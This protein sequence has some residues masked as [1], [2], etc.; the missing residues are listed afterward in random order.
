MKIATPAALAFS[1]LAV[2]AFA[3][4]P[5][6]DLSAAADLVRADDL[7]DGNVYSV[8]TG[9]EQATFDGATYTAIDAEWDDVGDIEDLVLDRSGQLVAVVAEIGG[10]LGLGDRHVLLPVTDV[11][12]VPGEGGD[13]AYV[14]RLSQ[15]E[16]KQLP[17]VEEGFWD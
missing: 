10:F 16:L 15:E 6:L 11:S 17:E 4:Q 8:A 9:I 13:F 3:Q 5:T 2:P 7:E 1:L 14:T 12:L